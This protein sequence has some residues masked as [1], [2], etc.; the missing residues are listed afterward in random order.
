[1]LKRANILCAV[2]IG[3]ALLSLGIALYRVVFQTP[4]EVTMGVVQ[5]IFY[6]HLPMAINAFVA[7]LVVFVSGIGYLW[8]RRMAWDDLGEAGAKVA[9]LLC[10]GVLVTG[11]IWGRS[12]WGVWWTWSPRLTF[13]LMLW[14]LYVVYLIIRTSI[15]S[16]ERRA[17][18]SAVYGIMAF[19]DVPIVWLSAKLLPDIHPSSIKLAAEMKLT[20]WIWFVPVT[21]LCAALIAMR[22][23]LNRKLRT[24][25]KERGFEVVV[26]VA[27][28]R[29]K[30]SGGVI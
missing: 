24:Q 3:A 25:V 5:K 18:V 9:V 23:S 8:Q 14:L 26:P 29:V 2:T 19:L 12:A 7:C 6:V 20:L 17:V 16:P 11:M 13:S 1:M 15:E 10:T 21:L 27:R 4:D 30:M 28:A 22:Y